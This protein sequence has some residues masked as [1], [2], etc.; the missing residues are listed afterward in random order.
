MD[1]IEYQAEDLLQSISQSIEDVVTKLGDHADRIVAAG[2]ATQRS[3]VACWD[4][5]SGEALSP[6]ISWQD[7]RAFHWLEQFSDQAAEIHASTGLFLSAH[8]G[9]SKLRWCLEHIPAVKQA[10]AEQ[11]LCFGPMSSFLTFRLTEEKSLLADPVNASRTQLWDLKTCDWNP[12]LLALFGIPHSALPECVPSHTDFGHLQIADRQI[13]LTLVSGD[14]SAAMY[15]FGKLQADTAY[16]NM[17]TGAFISRPSGYARLY[18]RRLLTSVIR[19]TDQ[20]TEYVLEGTVN[21]AG[22]ALKWFEREYHQPNLITKLHGWLNQAMQPPLFLNGISGLAAPFWIAEFPSKF[23]G[24]GDA[25]EQ[26]V[27]VVESIVF[28]LQASLD[29]MLKL[30]SRPD[31]LQITGGLSQLDGL[32]QR[33]ADLSSLAVYRPQQC[34]ATARGT[35]YLLADQPGHWP[36]KEAG[37]WFEPQSNPELQQ[38]YQHW[39]QAMLN[40]MRKDTSAD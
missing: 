15:A 29:E 7:R 16:I 18:G 39:Y 9:A 5:H 20:Q 30:A 6:I 34:E 8:Y 2:L 23:I 38:R 17:G 4:K 19:Q 21:G 11:R 10:L 22:S 35:A 31:Q 33:M 14:Q 12:Q 40:R 28:L 32:C 1:F 26:A 37:I 27:A 36:E 25:A 3:N 24:E 13:P